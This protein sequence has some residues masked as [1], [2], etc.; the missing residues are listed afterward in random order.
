MIPWI[1]GKGKSLRLKF[2]AAL[3]LVDKQAE[4]PLLSRVAS[5]VHREPH[6]EF[7]RRFREDNIRLRWI[8][9][10]EKYNLYACECN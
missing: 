6:I 9:Q 8:C 5:E 10:K 4:H 7:V 2:T 1:K 3:R